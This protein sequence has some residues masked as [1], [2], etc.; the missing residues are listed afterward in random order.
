MV[1]LMCRVCKSI[2]PMFG[3][4]K[5][6]DT[7]SGYHSICKYC[8]A[9][10]S[11]F[12][13]KRSGKISKSRKLIAKKRYRLKYPERERAQNLVNKAIRLGKLIRG[14]CM[15]CNNPVSQGHHFDYMKPLDV[16]WLC[17]YHHNEITLSRI[18]HR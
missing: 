4:H 10:E 5:R 12:R 14:P 16:I 11:S 18:R 6:P 15:V 2:K 9:I 13:K 8:K 17:Q 3:F 1:M 7:K